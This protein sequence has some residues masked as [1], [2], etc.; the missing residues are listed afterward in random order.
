MFKTQVNRL[1]IVVCVINLCFFIGCHRSYY[2][3]QADS[4][5]QRLVSEKAVD[6]RWNTSDGTIDIDPQ[7][8]M[9]NPFSQDHPPIPPDDASSHQL[10][11]RVDGKEG[12]PHWHANGDTDAVENPDWKSYLPMNEDGQVVLTLERAYQLALL[13]SPA[14]QQ[15][16]ETLYRS[17]LAVSLQRFGFDSQLFSGFNSFATTQGRFRGGGSSTSTIQNQIGANGGGAN[18]RRLGITGTNFA[19]GLANTILFNLAGPNTQS[20]TTLIDFSIIQPLLRGAGRERIMESLTQS[21]RTLLANVRQIERF[22]RGFYLNVAIGRNAGSGATLAANFLN[23]PGFGSDNTGGFYGLL[24]QQ[25]TIRNQE[26]NVRQLEGILGQFQEFFDKNRLSAVNLKQFENNVYV[27]QRGLLQQRVAYQNSLDAYKVQLGLPPDLDVI[28][29]DSYLDR[30]ELISDQIND[31]LISIAKL[32]EQ[33]GDILNLIYD[34]F[35]DIDKPGFVFPKNLN[36]KVTQLKPFVEQAERTLD[37]ILNEDATQLGADFAKLEAARNGRIEYLQRLATDVRTGRIASDVD[38]SLFDADS[39]PE[40]DD[41]RSGLG[42]LTAESTGDLPTILERGQKLKLEIAETLAKVGNFA[43][44]E[45]TLGEA[46]L[47][48]FIEEEFQQKIPGELAEMNNLTLEMTL[49]QAFARSNSIEIVNISID[50]EQAIRIARCMRRDW[51]NARASLVDEY[52]NIEF[53]ADQLEAGVD[54]VLQGNI[55]N[56]GDNPLK[57]RYENGQLRAGFRIDAPITRLAERNQYRGALISYQQ[58][59]RRFY[60]FEDSIKQNLRQL[61]RN[62]NRSKVIFELDRRTVQASIENVEINRLELE[63][64]VGANSSAFGNTLAQDLNRAI[65]GL[66]NAQ[67]SFLRTW[68]Q[69]E[70]LRRNLDFDMGTMMLDEMG[71]WRDPGEIDS[72]IGVRAAAVMGFEPDCQFCENI[73]TSYQPQLTE[74]DLE[75]MDSVLT[76]SGSGTVGFD[77]LD[78]IQRPRGNEVQQ[79]P[80]DPA[81]QRR[82]LQKQMELERQIQLQEIERERL[83]L[84]QRNQELQL[85]Q[86]RQQ[87][88]PQP[89]SGLLTP[90]TPNSPMQV[91]TPEVRSANRQFEDQPRGRTYEYQQNRSASGAS[92]DGGFIRPVVA[93]IESMPLSLAPDQSGREPAI[94][95]SVARQVEGINELA[96]SERIP[97]AKAEVPIQAEPTGKSMI[98]LAASTTDDRPGSSVN[99]ATKLAVATDERKVDVLQ[100]TSLPEMKVPGIEPVIEPVG[101]QATIARTLDK[102]ALGSS[103]AAET[104]QM[105][106]PTRLSREAQARIDY[107]LRQRASLAIAGPPPAGMPTQTATGMFKSDLKLPSRPAA[108]SELISGVQKGTSAEDKESFEWQQTESTFGGLLNRFKK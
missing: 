34:E 95:K 101:G 39:V 8:R 26:L 77:V 84:Q 59:R 71:Q 62:V 21:E 74:E 88:F 47:K 68:V 64:P 72:S 92:T 49:L 99:L 33:T 85:E 108:K 24:L 55:G 7:S 70:V 61:L 82:R 100:M 4:E 43:Q 98:R 56:V 105:P 10:M 30:F 83:E 90:R 15:Q 23:N 48:A 12:Y 78:L 22:K 106:S 58:S 107:E 45:Q 11:H 6:P 42:G 94:Q 54:L 91:L 66:N 65:A 18:L 79:A 51:M 35:D 13:H 52:R 20:A 86:L 44:T 103:D 69:Y 25:Q 67:N 57:L 102:R 32:R 60:Q 1:L 40:A 16:Y 81:D 9:F 46:E 28:I 63:R 37:G 31:R 3:R 2:R 50:D 89:D 87:Q 53:V 19:V 38:P 14:L 80:L 104:Q 97:P 5:A 41:L 36:A 17:A 75:N 27:Q 29:D 76:E 96:S 73:G 93:P